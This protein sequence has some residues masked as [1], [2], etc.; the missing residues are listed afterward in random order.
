M[1]EF[2]S[3]AGRRFDVRNVDEDLSAYRELVARGFR[4]VPVTIIGE[5]AIKGFDEPALTRALEA[6]AQ[7][8][9]DR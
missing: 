3:R 9:P 2:L 4:T 1:K 8:P 5:A 7:S 6:A